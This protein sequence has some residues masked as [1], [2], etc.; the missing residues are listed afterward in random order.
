MKKSAQI[1]ASEKTKSTQA[2]AVALVIGTL[3]LGVWTE[4]QAVPAFAR[5]TGMACNSCHFQGSYPAL[6]QFGR[7]F[8]A[9]GYTQSGAQELVEDNNLSLP[10]VLNASLITKFRYQKTNGDNARLVESGATIEGK[11][12]AYATNVGEL[13]LPDEAALFLGGRV[14]ENIGFLT[15]LSLHGTEGSNFLSFKMPFNF[16]AGEDTDLLVVP[17]I[18]DALGAG[19]GLEL[20]NTGA[21]RSQRVGEDRKSLMAQQ[22]LGLGYGAAEGITFAAVKESGFLNVTFWSPDWSNFSPEGLATYVRGALTPQL[23]DW[24]S[25]LG[26]QY[27]FGKSKNDTGGNIIEEKD[28]K[29]WSIDG[30]LQGEFLDKPLGA[31]AAY[32]SVP[33]NSH[34]NAST[35]RKTAWSI[36][37]QYGV[38]PNKATIILGYRHADTGADTDNAVT[39]GGTYN[40]AQNVQ[41]QLNHVLRSGSKYDTPQD[42]G[43]QQTTLMLFSGF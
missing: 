8:K 26:F 6:N 7:S 13:Q 3:G 37:G 14:S 33:S 20:L 1:F 25:G 22:Y 28:I 23:G 36:H 42:A 11:E 43:D 38:I 31:Y 27:Y 32:G 2:T 15:E 9:A 34:F 21:L 19:F 40:F 39:I 4:S 24:D 41:L 12:G 5:Q 17:F 29:G 18:T 35:N 16:K 30:Q 10:A